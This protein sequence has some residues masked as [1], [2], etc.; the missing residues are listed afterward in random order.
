MREHHRRLVQHLPLV[1]IVLDTD[2]RAREPCPEFRCVPSA[3][4]YERDGAL[5]RGD[6]VAD[7]GQRADRRR[8][9]V[10]PYDRTE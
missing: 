9:V 10:A 8:F 7:R 2:V 6:G 1:D 4:T 3:K 5:D